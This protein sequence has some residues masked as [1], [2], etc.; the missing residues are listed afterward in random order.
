MINNKE[1]KDISSTKKVIVDG[2]PHAKYWQGDGNYLF[3]P[4]QAGRWLFQHPTKENYDNLMKIARDTENG[5][6]TWCYPDK[7]KLSRMIGREV[8][9]CISQAE[10]LSAFCNLYSK[11]IIGIDEVKKVF[12]SLKSKEINYQNYL[13]ELPLVRN[14][15]EVILNGWMHAITRLIDYYKLTNE[16]DDLL[17]KTLKK[18]SESLHQ[19]DDEN[20]KI[21]KYSNLSIYKLKIT[22]PDNP[23]IYY[24]GKN[25]FKL[26]ENYSSSIY[27]CQLTNNKIKFSNAT[28][29]IPYEFSPKIFNEKPFSVEFN[30]GLYHNNI[31]VPYGDGE[32]IILNSKPSQNRHVIKIENE[33][34]FRGYPTPFTKI[35]NENY[36]HVYHIVA[37]EEIVKSY[38]SKYD[39]IFIEYAKKW[40]SYIDDRNFTKKSEVEIN[41]NKGK[42]YQ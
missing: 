16:T 30:V 23:E 3:H 26:E 37:L 7:Y 12:L 28:I 29:G 35:N 27:D 15:P 22:N 42:F 31:T 9:S 4:M 8:T 1:S 24:N 2:V 13:L 32:K 19:F 11:G 39:K 36:Y 41:I 40:E 25:I 33:N 38:P 21:S 5:G 17:E 14:Y 20:N 18:L 34:L 10:F 6:I